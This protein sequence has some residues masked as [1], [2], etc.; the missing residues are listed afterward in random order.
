MIRYT[1]LMN[2]LWKQYFTGREPIEA[3]KEYAIAT[4]GNFRK[5]GQPGPWEPEQR[6]NLW[7]YFRRQWTKCHRANSEPFG[8]FLKALGVPLEK[9][10]KRGL[11]WA[12]KY[13]Y[14]ITLRF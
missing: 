12:T 13:P 6:L 7:T 2:E 4:L 11:S 1:L 10:R 3:D 9:P 14:R 5:L 8:D